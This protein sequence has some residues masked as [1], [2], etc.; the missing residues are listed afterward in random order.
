[1]LLSYS[2]RSSS[3][4]DV[5][6]AEPEAVPASSQMPL[7]EV[8]P[9]VPP[10]EHSTVSACSFF[11]LCYKLWGLQC[12]Q[13][14]GRLLPEPPQAQVPQI[15]AQELQFLWPWQ[16]SAVWGF[17]LWSLLWGL[18]LTWSMM[19]RHESLEERHIPG[20][21]ESPA[22]LVFSDPGEHCLL[23]W[24]P[25]P[26]F[27]PFLWSPVAYPWFWPR[28]NLLFPSHWYLT[29]I[30]PCPS[31]GDNMCPSSLTLILALHISKA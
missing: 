11:L 10:K 8:L 6:P 9:K 23:V 21:K 20:V 4:Q 22:S 1:M 31:K 19:L 2:S 29:V 24:C 30:I 13:L 25:G 26:S 14:W 15:Q 27:P 17:R 5:L 3:C 7:P 12:P 18:L 28:I 16:W